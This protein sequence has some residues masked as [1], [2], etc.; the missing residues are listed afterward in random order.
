MADVSNQRAEGEKE[1]RRAFRQRGR[2]AEGQIHSG[3][4][5][6]DLSLDVKEFLVYV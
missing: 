2:Y 4:Y 3:P 6:F 5:T 1:G